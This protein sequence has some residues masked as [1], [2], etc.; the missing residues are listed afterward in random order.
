MQY[1]C[2][3]K[4]A[5]FNGVLFDVSYGSAKINLFKKEITSDNVIGI[6]KQ[7]NVPSHFDLLSVTITLS[8]YTNLKFV[9]HNVLPVFSKKSCPSHIGVFH[10]ASHFFSSFAL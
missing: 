8:N 1:P 10:F 5:Q 6:F 3:E 7:H 2:I 9:L 4:Y